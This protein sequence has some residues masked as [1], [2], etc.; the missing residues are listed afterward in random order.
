[1]TKSQKKP[2]P[3]ARRMSEYRERLRA[4]GLRQ[5]TLWLPDT[6]SPAFIKAAKKQ[7]MAIAAGDK[8]GDEMDAFIEATFE[9]PDP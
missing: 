3:T 6:N 7:S 9:W 8:A 2:V 5:V 1:M 4:A